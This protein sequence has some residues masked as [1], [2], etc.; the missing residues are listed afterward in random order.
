MPE[1]YNYL[2]DNNTGAVVMT[3]YSNTVRCTVPGS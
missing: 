1:G 3:A 2:V